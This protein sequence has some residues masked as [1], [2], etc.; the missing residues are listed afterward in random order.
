VTLLVQW[1]LRH[2]DALQLL[3]LVASVIGVILSLWLMHEAWLDARSV[4]GDGTLARLIA[5]SHLRSQVVILIVQVAFGVIS[6]LVYSLPAIPDD[7]GMDVH[8]LEVL[9]VIALRKLL[10]AGMILL[11]MG[12]ALRQAHDRRRLLAH[13]RAWPLTG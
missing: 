2:D 12:A 4:R 3:G 1:F 7:M 10:R 5:R 11:L 9:A 8:G 6:G 13:L